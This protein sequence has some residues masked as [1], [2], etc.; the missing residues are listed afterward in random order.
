MASSNG[1]VSVETAAVQAGLIL[2]LQAAEDACSQIRR[3]I[4]GLPCTEWAEGRAEGSALHASDVA[5][6][7]LSALRIQLQI[8]LDWP[9]VEAPDRD[10]D[11]NGTAY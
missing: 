2:R 5:G 10:A 9:D 8:R 11:E 7:A 6:Q 3:L 4:S 1:Q